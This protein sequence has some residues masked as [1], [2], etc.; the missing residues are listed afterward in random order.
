MQE[1]YRSL[2]PP[3]FEGKVLVCDVGPDRYGQYGCRSHHPELIDQV[4]RW[5]RQ[6]KDQLGIREYVWDKPGV[7]RFI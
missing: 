7:K 3:G 6:N 5:C 1:E 4:W 2:V